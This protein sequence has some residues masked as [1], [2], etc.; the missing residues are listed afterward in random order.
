MARVRVYDNWDRI[1]RA[2]LQREQLR[3]AGQGHERTPSGIAGSVPA[4]LTKSTNIDL[5]LQAAD[6][7]QDEDPNVARILCE[8]AYT[9]AQN[10]DPTSD[11][12]GVLQF[13]TGL[14]S[15]IKQKL[16]QKDGGPIDR[17]R[18]VERLWQFYQ[19]YKKRHKVDDIQKEELRLQETGTFSTNL[20]GF[21]LSDMKKTFAI[22]RALIE[23]MEALSENAAPDVGRL[24][25]EEL[26]RIKRADGE[27]IPYNIVPLDA[28]SITNAIGVFP[29][30]RG[31]INAIKY[32]DHFPKLPD[33]YDIPGQRDPDMFDLLE[34]VFGFQRDNVRN[35]RE[36]VV[37]IVA[38]A[39]SR[40]EIPTGATPVS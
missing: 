4:S 9:M 18:D 30:V 27:L 32:A 19:Q 40:L 38:N 33:D 6:Q 17:N 25:K 22:L 26:R 16:A 34:C 39:Q 5:I 14:M 21:E 31:A 10:L 35:Q 28:P 8:Q 11:G 2:T 7:I 3:N 37:L 29:E 36:H 15:V 1:V 12:R 23:V 20:G 24:I 13:K